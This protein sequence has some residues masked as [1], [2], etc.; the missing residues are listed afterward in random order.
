MKGYQI[1]GFVFLANALVL[2]FATKIWFIGLPFFVIGIIY[3][4]YE[5]D[6]DKKVR[7]KK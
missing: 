5:E 1:L 6:K 3:L 7:K 2:G 4:T